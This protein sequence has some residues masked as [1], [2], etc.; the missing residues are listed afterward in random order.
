MNTNIIMNISITTIMNIAIL[1]TSMLLLIK[2][3]QPETRVRKRR[4]FAFWRVCSLGG[5]LRVASCFGGNRTIMATLSRE[6]EGL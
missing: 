3:I 1:M 5:G 6:K 4:G 2:L